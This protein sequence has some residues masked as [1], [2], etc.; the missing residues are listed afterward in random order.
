MKPRN[1]TQH[2][3]H[4]ERRGSVRGYQA[5]DNA[6]CR[7][8]LFCHKHC[9]QSAQPSDNSQPVTPAVDLLVYLQSHLLIMS[10]G[11][12]FC[13]DLALSLPSYQ[14]YE[15]AIDLLLGTPLPAC[16][17]YSLSKP[18]RGYREIHHQWL[19]K[20]RCHALLS[21][22]RGFEFFLCWKEN[23]LHRLQGFEP[24]HYWE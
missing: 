19:P 23:R 17:L 22:T 24:N 8:S 3:N 7:S 4:I 13:K 9:L 21:I 16:H 18:E 5:G 11:E 2:E 6:D 15:C 14:L 12:V 1:E 10:W 20:S